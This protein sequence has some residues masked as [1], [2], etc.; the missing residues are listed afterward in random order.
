MVDVQLNLFTIVFGTLIFGL[1]Y[2]G[3]FILYLFKNKDF[4]EMKIIDKIIQS[5]LLGTISFILTMQSGFMTI[6]N[7][8]KEQDMLNYVI[9]NPVIF[10]YQFFFV[11]IFVYALL[12][13][14]LY[15][16]L[17]LD[18]IKTKLAIA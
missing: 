9:I 17:I 5:F 1:G 18:K 3:L 2:L 13:G 6:L 10:F 4:Y 7:M 8:T 11:I 16:R 15:I 14:E 12:I